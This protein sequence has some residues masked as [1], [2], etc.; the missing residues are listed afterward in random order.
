MKKRH[1]A[2]AV[3]GIAFGERS[4]RKALRRQQLHFE[5]DR[6]A[7]HRV[8]QNSWSQRRKGA[9]QRLEATRRELC[10]EHEPWGRRPNDPLLCVSASLRPI[11]WANYIFF[12][13]GGGG[14]AGFVF[15]GGGGTA[16]LV[17]VVS[18]PGTLF[19]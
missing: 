11:L 4:A 18:Q 1:D 17:V 8:P 3:C 14:T 5:T 6:P 16:G 10:D 7:D 2:S 9:K 19:F 15:G 12:G 13:G